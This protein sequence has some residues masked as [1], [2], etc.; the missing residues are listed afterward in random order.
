MKQ[1]TKYSNQPIGTFDGLRHYV[2]PATGQYIIAGKGGTTKEQ[3]HKN[4]KLVRCRE[5][6]HEFGICGKWTHLLRMNLFEI[7]HLCFGNYTS[8]LNSF[9]K[10]I[11]KKDVV[12]TKGDRNIESSKYKSLLTSLNFNE[13]HPFKQVLN[14]DPEVITDAERKT[15]TVN[16]PKFYSYQELSW[17]RPFSYYRLSLQIGQLSD[18]LWDEKE[19]KYA[20]EYWRAEN[21]RVVVRSEWMSKITDPVD[22]SLTASFADDKLPAEH[23]TVT[24]GLGIEI[25]MNEAPG[26]ISFNKGDGT[27][28]LIACL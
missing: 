5:N 13:R 8:G 4:P 23:V 6:M 28:A 11:Q 22:I 15:I 3:L 19:Q 18:Y 7:I 9:A 2:N 10:N 25:G 24:V 16:I 20:P 27:M 14:R 12:G 26:T 1:S 21:N 17:P